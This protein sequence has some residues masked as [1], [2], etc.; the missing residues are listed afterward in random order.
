MACPTVTS[1]NAF[2]SSVLAHVDCQAQSIGSFGYGA[3]ASANSPIAGLMLALLTLF[4]AIFGL[5][6]M[7][8]TGVSARDGVS[9]ALKVGIVLTLATSWPAWRTLAYD[10]V[11]KG[12]GEVSASIAGNAGLPY[13]PSR[14]EL[15]LQNLDDG[16]VALTAFGS[17][18]LT[19]GIA[20]STDLGDS[21]S[22]V[23]LPD[24]SGLGLGRVAYLVGVIAPLGVTRLGGG[25][26]LALA[27][28][29]A[30]LLLF[31]ATRSLFFG[32]L[33]A[34]G[35]CAIGAM[36][37]ALVY[38]AQLGVMEPWLTDTLARRQ[39]NVLMPAAP[40][41]LLVLTLAFA[42]L[43]LAWLALLGKFL[44]FSE[45]TFVLWSE[46]AADRS[47]EALHSAQPQVQLSS[48]GDSYS[49]VQ[50]IA[51]AVSASVA[52]EERLSLSASGGSAPSSADAA[53]ASPGSGGRGERLGSSYRRA[54]RRV[55]AA[56]ERRD[57]GQ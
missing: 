1:G 31:G 47:R 41:E 5:R 54:A 10:V 45:S 2:L 33:R 57:A 27:P 37:L 11:F 29:L 25:I 34:L 9:A 24:Q 44:F 43:A 4:I 14:L 50:T 38:A 48:Q 28:L 15:R 7:L 30:G 40:T 32:Y 16:I 6:L 53:P 23:A 17:G 39:S 26:L 56:A 19:G 3:L 46:G 21:T 55:S 18:R 36:G 13:G 42:L 49:R 20:G 52:R 35:F 51:G 22:G 12:P 8:G